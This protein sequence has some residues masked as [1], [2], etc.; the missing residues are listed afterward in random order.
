[1]MPK[2]PSLAIEMAMVDSV[3]VSMGEEIMGKLRGIFFEKLEA[4]LH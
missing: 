1:M 4:I 3:T 2:P